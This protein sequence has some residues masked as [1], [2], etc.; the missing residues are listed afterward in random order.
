MRWKGIDIYFSWFEDGVR[1]G[2][3][4]TVNWPYLRAAL[5]YPKLYVR[6]TGI[7]E[8]SQVTGGECISRE[9][10]DIKCTPYWNP[11]RLGDPIGNAAQAVAELRRCTIDCVQAWTLE[12]G[13]I[14]HTLSGGLDSSIIASCLARMSAHPSVTA[15]SLYSPGS[16][17][18]EREF[19]RLAAERAGIPMMERERDI[20]VRL[21]SLRSVHRSVSPENYLFC[22]DR[23]LQMQVVRECGAQAVM[24]GWGGDQV[25][26]QSQA[27]YG[28]AE[29]LRHH[30]F[31]AGLFGAAMDAARM[32]RASVWR[33]LR[34]AFRE[35]LTGRRWDCRDE[36]GQFKKLLR[37][38][39]IEST[40]ESDRF[41]HPWFRSIERG[42]PGAKIWHAFQLSQPLEYYN[43]LHDE[44]DPELIAPLFSQPLI[45]LALRIPVYLHTLRG[46]DRAI[47]RRA[48]QEDVPAK[49]ILRQAKGSQE[50]YVRGILMRQFKFARQVLLD[51]RLVKE[52][53]LDRRKLEEAMSA[54]PGGNQAGASEIYDVL[55]M[56]LWLD[57]Q[58]SCGG[59]TSNV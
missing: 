34:G 16:N 4:L 10:N 44:S 14:L 25:F 29:Y 31:H 9:R 8:A 21:E 38:E 47:A 20:N 50:D 43:P 46:W 58:A 51:G 17:T 26:Y 49:I 45:E 56:E 13:S 30:G 22:L 1:L 48:F 15:L 27:V 6:E 18:D 35:T 37:A 53:I 57:R 19:A 24:T 12:R 52:G 36:T 59:V 55:S 42:V 33:V 40:R 39:V 23:R 5:C 2:R 3:P 7:Q 11:F 54:K 32:D 41:I 28:V